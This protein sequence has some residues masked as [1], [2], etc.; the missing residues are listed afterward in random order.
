[1]KKR[2]VVFL[3]SF[4]FLFVGSLSSAAQ[5]AEY[6]EKSF[7]TYIQGKMD[8]W[9][10]MISDMK[11]LTD[12]GRTLEIDLLEYYYGLIG[13]Y[14]DVEQNTKAESCLS[15]ALQ[16]LKKVEKSYPDAM[17]LKALR[18]NFIGFQIA[19]SPI[20]APVLFRSMLHNAKQSIA[21]GKEN[22]LVN[23]LYA[24]ILFYM[25][26]MFGGNKDKAIDHYKRA[27]E[28]MEQLPGGTENNWLYIQ[29]LASIGLVYEKLGNYVAAEAAYRKVAD[30]QPQY[31][32]VKTV[33][34]PRVRAKMKA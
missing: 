3:L 32:H 9:D 23:V 24:N 8:D 22:P 30:L 11:S 27:C 15:K 12:P 18:A 21:N 34:L 28:L 13:H 20:K 1:M 16:L 29:S 5:E 2:Q 26:E 33:L 10:S 14:I 17:E 19:L 4:L 31:V 25:P 6:R 7:Q